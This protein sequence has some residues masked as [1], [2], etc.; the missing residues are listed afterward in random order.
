MKYSVITLSI[1]FILQIPITNAEEK[2]TLSTEVTEV[3]EISGQA[4]KNHN[5]SPK[6]AMVNGPFGDDLG[7]GDIARSITPITKEM[8]EQLNITSLQDIL[9]VS[10]NSYSASGFGA[11]SLPTLRGQL[12]EL[13]QDGMRRQAGN[14]GF[15]I[16]LSFNSVDQIDVVKGAPTVLFGSSQRNGGFVNLQ[17]KKASIDE[18]TAQINLTAGRWDQYS[19]QI[20]VGAPIIEGESG[21]RVSAEHIDN[22]SF[23]DYSSFKSDSIFTAFRFL[24]DSQSTWDINFE[25]YQVEFTDN[26]GINRPTQAL[27]DDGL[28]ITGQGVQSNGST[29]PG[30][31]AIVSPTGQVQISRSNVLTDPDNENDAT[32]F[33]LHSTYTRELGGQTLLKNT[34]YYQHLTR[35]EIA[36]N[37]FV[38]IIDGAHT[39]QNRLE[40][41]HDWNNEQQTIFAVDVRYN[42]VLGYSQF[43]TEADLPIDLTGPI[44]NR[45]I[46][47]TIEQQAKLVE[48]RPGL[49]VSPGGQYDIN[50]DNVGDFSLSDTTDS[51]TWQT[52]FAIQQDSE[53]SDRLRTNLGY[54]IDFY[55]VK[56]R[57]PLAPTGQEAAKD[58]IN[59]TLHSGQASINYKLYSDIT[60]YAAT[61]YNQATSNSMAGGITL[62]A[63]N[64]ISAQNFATDNTLH[65]VGL[66]YIPSDSSWYIDTAIFNQRRSLRNR[67]GSNTGI[68]TKGLELQVFYDAAPYWFNL[69][70]SYIDARYDN[71]TSSK[72]STQVA[73]AFDN[74]RPDIIE[75]TG[76]G[77]PNFASFERSNR[78]LQGIPEQSFTLNG[79][80][81]I[82]DK[83]QA[84]FAALY[85][86]SYP[87]DYLATV[88]IRDQYTLNV[89]S[90][91]TINKQAKLRVDVNNI[92]NQKN[93]R[94]VFEG[95]YFG[96]TLVFPEL[97]IHAKVTLQYTF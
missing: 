2:S 60:V 28:Y 93:W 43:T 70:Y 54:R 46:P 3:I 66:K 75:G 22:G 6:N 33:L 62:G 7:L 87:L 83:W 50:G 90:S 34:S 4:I 57:D 45:R 68:E 95:G 77:A 21:I 12:G 35:D 1:L 69:G 59:E 44:E 25:Y 8:M 36:Q 84:G 71:S 74:S 92:T 89:N 65:E 94:P 52:G 97:P 16:P 55:D 47:L 48:L 39:A 51:T 5:I 72:S 56:A 14:N 10:P 96:S 18:R 32:T 23:Y 24:P 64:L 73:D 78:R 11:P 42:K 49:F 82:T 76:V 85:T 30:A 15:G 31:G 81:Y 29:I 67:D 20:D 88:Q 79:G 53:W 19:A 13:F 80:R 63:D 17:S 61:S 86:S 38:E 41:S 27:I 40:L 91:Y 58:T 37:S 26:A 9:A